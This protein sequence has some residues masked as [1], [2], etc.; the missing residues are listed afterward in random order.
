MKHPIFVQYRLVLPPHSTHELQP[1]NVGV[2][3]LF[4]TYFTD[5]FHIK[6][7]EFQIGINSIKTND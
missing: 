7:S 6:T 4:K 1:F 2:S 5:T 3:S